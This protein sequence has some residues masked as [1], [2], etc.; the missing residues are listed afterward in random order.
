MALHPYARVSQTSGH[1]C[2]TGGMLHRTHEGGDVGVE[3]GQTLIQSGQPGIWTMV[4]DKGD[5]VGI[6]HLT[7]SN[8][9]GQI[10]VDVRQ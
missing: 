6:R 3:F 4:A 2:E 10:R 1:G 9:L 8:H 7:M 5:E